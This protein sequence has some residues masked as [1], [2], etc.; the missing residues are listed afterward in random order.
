MMLKGHLSIEMPHM[1]LIFCLNNVKLLPPALSLV[2]LA[3]HLP[4]RVSLILSGLL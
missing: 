3:I 4:Y 2:S 1:L